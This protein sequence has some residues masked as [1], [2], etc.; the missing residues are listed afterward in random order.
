MS[1]PPPDM[2][3]TVL[4][5]PQ[6]L[7]KQARVLHRQLQN[8]SCPHSIGALSNI[9]DVLRYKNCNLEWM[10]VSIRGN[11][12]EGLEVI[13]HVTSCPRKGSAME[14]MMSLQHWRS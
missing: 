3:F 10:F 6:D 4:L 11:L 7:A 9:E 8:A 2:D 5:P 14:D 13:G 1:L 12:P